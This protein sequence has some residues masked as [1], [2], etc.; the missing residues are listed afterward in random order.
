MDEVDVSE[1]LEDEILEDEATEVEEVAE[2]VAEEERSE[3]VDEAITEERHV[4]NVGE[5]DEELIVTFGKDMTTDEEERAD[6]DEVKHRAMALERGYIDEDSRRV[7][8]AISSEEPVQRSFGM[9]VLEHSENAIDLIVPQK[10]SRPR[11]YWTTIQKSKLA[12]SNRLTLM[13]R[14][15]D[16]VRRFASE[17]VDL[18]K[19]HSMTLLMAYVP[20]SVSVTPSIRW[21]GIKRRTIDISLV[22]GDP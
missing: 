11:C 21:S 6:S 5:T 18:L 19:R 20:I 17:E 14:H 8:M 4:K 15:V 12:L 13:A 3:S 9:E 16:C 10:R 1:F 2:E 7:K 22:L